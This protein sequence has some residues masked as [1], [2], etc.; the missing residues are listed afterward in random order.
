M[1]HTPSL[2]GPRPISTSPLWRSRRW[3]LLRRR[4]G[5]FV[6]LIGETLVLHIQLLAGVEER[7]V[8]VN[9]ILHGLLLGTHVLEQLYKHF[10]W[11]MVH[12]LPGQ[13]LRLLIVL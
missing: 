4:S 12:Q 8:P 1:M 6:E 3:C 7:P 2:M 10:R 13:V 11:Q 9:K 5:N